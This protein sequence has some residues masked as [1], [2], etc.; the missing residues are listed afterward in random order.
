MSEWATKP[1]CVYYGHHKCATT[2]INRIL[3]NASQELGYRFHVEWGNLPEHR[4][5]QMLDRERPDVLSLTN[6]R[7]E[8]ALWL[9]GRVPGFHVVRDPRDVSVSG[10]WSHRNSH[11]V[12]DGFTHLDRL[13]PT[14]NSLPLEDGLLAEMD[15][16][17]PHVYE[18]MSAWD[19]TRPNVLELRMEDLT[20]K[21]REGW[22]AILGFLGLTDRP[23][24]PTGETQITPKRLREIVDDSAFVRL[25]GGREQGKEDRNSH[26][27]KGVPGDWRNVFTQRHV[28]R[29]RQ[30][31]N[32]LLLKLGY[33]ETPDW[34]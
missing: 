6:A 4:F 22:L 26:Y 14:L 7:A 34:Q 18:L 21:P 2:W 27:R 24:G 12:V 17:N 31:H 23:G 15:F 10:Y 33:E 30:E 16:L 1:R 3:R 5:Q 20:A 19:Y 25:T 9:G 28:E 32:E 29:F 8:Y 13:R 11:P